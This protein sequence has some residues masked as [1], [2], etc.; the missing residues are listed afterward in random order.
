MGRVEEV[1]KGFK[2]DLKG[3]VLNTVGKVEVEHMGNLEG[4][5]GRMEGRSKGILMVGLKGMVKVAPKGMEEE[6]QKDIW[7][8]SVDM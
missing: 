6:V 2:V 7:V 1:V 8:G 5:M 3:L 4:S